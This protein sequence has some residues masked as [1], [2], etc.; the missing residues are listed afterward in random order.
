MKYVT[1]GKVCEYTGFF[2]YIFP[3]Y[4]LGFCMGKYM[5]NFGLEKTFIF[6]YLMQCPTES[7]VNLGASYFS[8]ALGKF[9]VWST[10]LG[11]LTSS[12]AFFLAATSNIVHLW[13]CND[14]FIGHQYWIYWIP[15]KFHKI[16][17]GV[18][19]QYQI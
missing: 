7:I 17:T 8:V 9:W 18:W 16:Q 2:W 10:K 3:L 6:A 11:A 12:S 14:T 5:G 19:C 4:V 13:Q 15:I 1:L